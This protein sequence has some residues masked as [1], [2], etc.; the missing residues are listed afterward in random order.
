MKKCE[1]CELDRKYT[2]VMTSGRV[3]CSGCYLEHYASQCG[4][5]HKKT[6]RVV[7]TFV[8]VQSRIRSIRNEQKGSKMSKKNCKL[9]GQTTYVSKRNII[10]I[11][12]NC[13]DS[14]NSVR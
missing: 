2:Q 5:S 4:T 9:C 12:P 13:V 3:V 6:R 8:A 14:L 7:L 11:C 1:I 10:A